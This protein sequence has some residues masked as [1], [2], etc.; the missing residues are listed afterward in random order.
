MVGLALYAIA[1]ILLI[2]APV[3]NMLFVIIY[4][5]IVAVAECFVMP[6]KDTLIQLSIN[7]ERCRINA[8]IMSFT[9][10]FSSHS[11]ILQD[12]YQTDRWLLFAFA[13]ALFLAAF[14]IVGRIRDPEFLSII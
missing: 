9:I 4:V 8:L 6:R 11:V 12:G 10:A 13:F 14:I 5:F 7:A 2:L 3:G 1:V